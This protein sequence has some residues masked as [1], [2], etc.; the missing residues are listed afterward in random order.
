MNDQVSKKIYLAENGSSYAI[1]VQK[2]GWEE[3][4]GSRYVTQSHD[5]IGRVR[6]RRGS[7]REQLD[8]LDPCKDTRETR[9]EG[10]HVVAD[11]VRWW[12]MKKEKKKRRKVGR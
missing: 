10:T 12:W 6:E 1:V 11:K 7:R 5:L 4:D 8:P 2:E 9:R 3:R